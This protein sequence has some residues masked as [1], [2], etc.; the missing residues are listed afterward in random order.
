MSILRT[1]QIQDTGTNVAANIS[2]GTITAS[3]PIVAPNIITSPSMAA[4]KWASTDQDNANTTITPSA[5]QINIGNNLSGG[6]YTCPVNGIYRATIWG[7]AGGDGSNSDSSK[8]EAYLSVNDVAPTD[9]L[10]HIYV[11]P[12]TTYSHFSANFLITMTANQ[13]LRFGLYA[14]KRTLHGNHGQATFKLEHQT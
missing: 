9:T 2:G 12:A 8:F 11:N 13:N 3:N 7:M 14:N 5:I 4:F 1:N 10:Y 6:V